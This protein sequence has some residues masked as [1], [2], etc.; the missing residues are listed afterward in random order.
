MTGVA[1]ERVMRQTAD[2]TFQAQA[3]ALRVRERA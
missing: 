3:N 1:T 2:R